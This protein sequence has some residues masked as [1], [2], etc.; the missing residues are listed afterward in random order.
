VFNLTLGFW[1]LSDA[2]A[3]GAACAEEAVGVVSDGELQVQETEGRAAIDV[4]K[5]MVLASMML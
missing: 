1:M 2:A 3:A 4:R 5:E